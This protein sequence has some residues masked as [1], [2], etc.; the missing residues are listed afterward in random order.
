LPPPSV[1]DS[2]KGGYHFDIDGKTPEQLQRSPYNYSNKLDIDA[3]NSLIT[4][5]K[6]DKQLE[7]V[8]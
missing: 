7:K 4:P 5:G 2:N 8:I 1:L 3:S 6:F